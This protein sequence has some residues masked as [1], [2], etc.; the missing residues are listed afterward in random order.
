MDPYPCRYLGDARRECSC[1][2]GVGAAYRLRVFR[3]LLDRV[4]VPA[5]P[6]HDL[7]ASD[8]GEDSAAIRDRVNAARQRQL[9]RSVERADLFC[10]AHMDTRQVRQFCR[11][12]QRGPGCWNWLSIDWGC[13]HAPMTGS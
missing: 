5:V 8:A 7:A 10:N 13:P 6:Y 1:A 4:E 12:D 2:P 3:P 9:A 11:P